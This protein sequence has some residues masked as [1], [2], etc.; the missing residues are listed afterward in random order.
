MYAERAISKIVIHLKGKKGK[1]VGL[2]GTR[3]SDFSELVL[4]K[5]NDLKM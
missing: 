4:F 2:E 3:N 1:K 5:V